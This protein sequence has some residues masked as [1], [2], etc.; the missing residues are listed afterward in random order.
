MVDYPPFQVISTTARFLRRN[1]QLPLGRLRRRIARFDNVVAV[2]G[3]AG[4]SCTTRLIGEILQTRAT[5]HVRWGLNTFDSTVRGLAKSKVHARYWVQ[6]VSGHSAKDLK[7]SVDFIRPDIAVVTN[8]QFDHISEHRSLDVTSKSKGQL[9]EALSESGTA[10]LNADDPRVMAMATQCHGRVTTFGKSE[11]ADIRVLEHTDGLPKRLTFRVTDGHTQS[12]VETGYIGSRWVPNFLAAIAVGK[13]MGFSLEQC[14]DAL[15]GAKP[16]TYKD[17][18]HE[19][20]G[21]TIVLDTA[22]SPY[23]TI[24]GSLDIVRKAN[25][26]RKIMIFGTISDY[27]GSA[28]SKYRDAA[29]RALAIADI[30]IFYG[31]QCERPAKLKP[32]YGERL[33][34]FSNYSKLD[35]F[36]RV[37]LR[38]GDLVY[39]KSSDADYLERVLL[40]RYRQEICKRDDCTKVKRCEKCRSLYPG[41]IPLFDRGLRKEIS[42]S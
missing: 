14:A 12:V 16:E 39:A 27:R 33:Q 19:K 15:K 4:K 21:V 25:Y 29:R 31:R 30:V 42:Q 2:T 1:W 17:S 8:V 22:K 5:V 37:N 20:D 11:S 35:H 7:K 28:G 18:I 13:A 40:G 34:F 23:W 38:E 36:L 26:P 32:E 10:I 41:R 9:V 24:P 3:S 6:E